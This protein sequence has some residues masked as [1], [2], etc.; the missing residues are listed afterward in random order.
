M[1]G[2]RGS[3]V[4]RALDAPLYFVCYSREDRRLVDRI[5]AKLA[6]ARRRGELELWQDVRSLDVWEQFT[7]EIM[8]AIAAASGAVVIVSD[9]WYASDYI[10][11]YEWPTILARA[12][13]DERFGI[14]P[15]AIGRLGAD[16]PLRERTFVNDVQTELLVDAGDD[17]RDRVLTGLNDHLTAHARALAEPTPIPPSAPG[18]VAP[19]STPA[20]HP[21]G[22]HELRP[23]LHGVPRIPGFLVRPAEADALRRRILG[24]PTTA[25]TGLTGDGGTGKTTLAAVV[26]Y[27]LVDAF[28]A[29]VHW[30][31]VGEHATREDVRQLLLSL[32][33]SLGEQP[34]QAVRD[35]AQAA[36]LLRRALRDSAALVVVDDVWHPWQARAFSPAA[37]D[38]PARV[39]FTSRFPDAVPPTAASIEV[40]RLRAGT[41][42]AFL[43][44]TAGFLPADEDT[45][46][47]VLDAADGLRLALAVLGAAARIDGSWT[48]VSGRLDGLTERFG[49]R[50]DA[51]SAHKALHVAVVGLAP[52]D[53]ER[54]WTLAAFPAD[55][56]IPL[57]LLAELWRIQTAAA[58]E[59][60]LRLSAA[61]LVTVGAGTLKLHDHVN[62]FL[63]LESPRASADT[64]L[65]L[66][67][68][69]EQEVDDHGWSGLAT[70]Q[71]Y[72]WDRLVWHAVRAE[73]NSVAIRAVAIDVERL[74]E[75]IRR[76]GAGAAEQ[77][78][79]IAA[80]HVGARSDEPVARLARVL[81]HGGLFDALVDDR[82]GLAVS[83]EIWVQAVGVL[84]DGALRLRAGSLPIP[85]AALVRTFRGHADLVWAVAFDPF[86]GQL[87]TGSADGTVKAWD[88]R[89]GEHLQ[90]LTG[91]TAAV[92]DAAFH[93]R[94]G[95]LATVGRDGTARLWNT[96]TGICDAVLSI[97]DHG[98]WALAFDTHG[99]RMAT[100]CDD[101]TARIWDLGAGRHLRTL[102]GHDAPV[103]AVAF[104]PA[105]DH[106]A[107]GSDDGTARLWDLATGRCLRVFPVH[108][109]GVWACHFISAARRLATASRDGVVRIWDTETGRCLTALDGHGDRIC[110]AAVDPG[111]GRLA[112]ASD[113][114]T[115]RIWEPT[116]GQCTAVLEGHTNQVL[117]VAFD[118]TSGAL[119]SG[120]DDGTARLWNP[121]IAEAAPLPVGHSGAVRAMHFGPAAGQPT[122]AGRDGTVRVWDLTSGEPLAVLD[123][124][125]DHISGMAV[126]NRSALLAT[127]S[128]DGTARLW[129]LPTGRPRGV[130]RGHDGPV[131]D[132][133]IDPG[134]GRVA[135]SGRDATARIW[136]PRTAA[137]TAVCDGHRD[138]VNA[139]AFDPS[140]GLLATASDDTTVR[141]W[142]PGTGAVLTV[143]SGH[144]TAV[145]DL[146]FETG[147]GRLASAGADAT[148][149]I[150]DPRTGECLRVLRGHEN[151]V[152]AVAF[153][154][155]TGRVVSASRDGTARVWDSETGR[156]LLVLALACSGPLALDGALLAVAAGRHWA[157][158]ELPPPSGET[159]R[160]ATW[161]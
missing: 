151:H 38:G 47:A 32:L 33:R 27:E 49:R 53:R 147:T 57:S 143:L 85:T 52:E 51:S 144:E 134:T 130:L 139:V 62:D 21:P 96:H 86:D 28:P 123:C 136:D 115:V 155:A 60:A 74:T 106:L 30:V 113:D 26:A 41:A 11:T 131:W 126:L 20:P 142:D 71:P 58:R 78:L 102:I 22:R 104:N 87:A 40:G 99:Q 77:D 135:T 44:A 111:S 107:T 150:W 159:Q 19:P 148:V 4:R 121:D 105:A 34:T 138:E 89:T 81:R 73:R 59:S 114:G 93:P 68:L 14:F 117:G 12:D 7:P 72:L 10:H 39:V 109:S 127:A 65:A 108:P 70:R 88:P 54:L 18:P 50:A 45:I 69:A 5:G 141:V 6:A 64:H 67:E 23:G 91:H 37:A 56:A 100:A 137:G 110:D 133:A 48:Q 43:A 80:E 15:L 161:R 3:N 119:A 157:L 118:P 2:R 29:G 101:G 154:H 66:W 122:T 98:I 128:R 35:H 83:V 125:A 124:H 63:T 152:W 90:T 158:V 92:H 116:T 84:T 145:W 129:D 1:F 79:R 82:A 132:V 120:G 42:R 46:D 103:C 25:V 160:P 112:T 61:A 16:D 76:D 140:T 17:L 149:R 146:A 75:R 13:R 31:T 95:Q 55:V 94:T 8:A 97:V 156:Q 24:S 9:D 36:E 153:D